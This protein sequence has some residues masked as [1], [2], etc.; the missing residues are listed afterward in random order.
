MAYTAFKHPTKPVIYVES[1][2][3][4]NSVSLTDEEYNQA[5]QDGKLVQE[6]R[7]HSGKIVDYEAFETV[8]AM[9]RAL[10]DAGISITHTSANAVGAHFSTAVAAAL[11]SDSLERAFLY[12]PTNISDRNWIWLSVLTGKEILT[13][14]KYEKASKDPLK[15]TDERRDM[16]KRVM[17]EA[18]KG[19]VKRR[20][21]QAQASTHNLGKLKSQQKMF[22]R[23]NKHG[24]AAAVQL[25]AAQMRHHALSQTIVLPEFAAQYKDPKDFVEFMAHVKK[26]GGNIIEIAD[27]ESLSVPLGQYGHSHYPTVRQ[28]LESYAF[29]R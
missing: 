26:L 20:V 9:V 19:I 8:Q 6:T 15:L 5:A 7:D 17:G 11:P 3:N 29:Q 10:E 23:G 2:G 28:T 13:Q 14:G 16:A 27:V 22:R 21:Q 25:V 24:Q 12:N 1:P 4:G 18:S